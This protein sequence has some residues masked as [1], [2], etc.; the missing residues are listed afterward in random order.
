M[1]QQVHKLQCNRLFCALP[2][3]ANWGGQCTSACYHVSAHGYALGYHFSTGHSVHCHNLDLQV[4]ILS[5][6]FNGRH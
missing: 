4:V 1:V 5:T 3:S 6:M 2:V